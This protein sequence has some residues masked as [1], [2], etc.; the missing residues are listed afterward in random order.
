[1]NEYTVMLI[2][3]ALLG[4]V[5]SIYIR[6]PAILL[7]TTASGLG[8]LYNIISDFSDGV[9]SSGAVATIL[10]II[11]IIAV[12]FSILGWVELVTKGNGRRR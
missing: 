3:I 5:M 10:S 6:H 11:M 12:A 8:G 7:I 2:V 1:M 4:L 9:I